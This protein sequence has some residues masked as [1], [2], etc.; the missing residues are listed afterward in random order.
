MNWKNTKIYNFVGV[1]P[2]IPIAH[3]ALFGCM[4]RHVSAIT[5]FSV[6]ALG[7]EGGTKGFNAIYMRFVSSIFSEMA[8]M[9]YWLYAYIF[10]YFFIIFF[11]STAALL[12]YITA[13]QVLP[14]WFMISPVKWDIYFVFM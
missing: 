13:T 8:N 7:M 5:R 9:G 14:L 3:L 6:T 11:F 2:I 1:Q 4:L 12:L 10:R